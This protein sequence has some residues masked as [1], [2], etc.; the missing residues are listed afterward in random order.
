MPAPSI[1]PLQG[2]GDRGASPSI[3]S[4]SLRSWELGHWGNVLSVAFGPDGRTIVS[5]SIDDTVRLWE[6]KGG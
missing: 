1:R 3:M 4:A 2:R 6:A 5:G